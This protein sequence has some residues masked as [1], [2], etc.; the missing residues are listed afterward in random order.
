MHLLNP[1]TLLLLLITPALS[2]LTLTVPP[3]PLLPNPHSLPADTHATLTSTS[4]ANPI[5][6]PLTRSATFVFSGI[7]SSEYKISQRDDLSGSYL[8]DIRSSEYVFTPL[9]VDLDER[10][11]VK[12]VWETFR[13]NEW[14]NR[15][16]E[17]YLRP[18]DVQVVAGQGNAGDVVVDVKVVGRKGFYE[19]RQ[20]CM[21]FPL[22]QSPPFICC[23]VSRGR[24]SNT[25]YWSYANILG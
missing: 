1:L 24:S 10:G 8:L 16:V 14:G 3:S 9:R 12:G 17:K 15:G 13:G 4:L 25:V 22:S 2:D 5:K 6:A 23:F 18:V 11:Y 20:T 21:C 19:V 7:A